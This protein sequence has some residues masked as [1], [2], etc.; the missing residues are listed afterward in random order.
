MKYMGSY[1]GGG[2]VTRPKK[3]KRISAKPK[4][5]KRP[6]KEAKFRFGAPTGAPEIGQGSPK[7]RLRAPQSSVFGDGAPLPISSADGKAGDTG[8]LLGM[9][10]SRY[11]I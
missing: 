3:L 10:L 9:V 2:G 4:K 6:K 5:L 1:G 11:T 7:R 8:G